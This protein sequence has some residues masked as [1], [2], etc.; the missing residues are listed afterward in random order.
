LELLLLQ[1]ILPALLEQ[2]HT[3]IWLKALIRGWCRVVA[4]LLNLQSYLLREQ[5]D[6]PEPAVVE[7][8]QH[9]DLGAAHQ[10]L[11]QREGPFGFQPYVRPKWFPA[12]LLGLLLCVCASLVVASL[13][14]MTLPVW[15]GRRVMALWMVGAPAPSPPVLPPTPSPTTGESSSI[16]YPQD[17]FELH[18]MADSPLGYFTFRYIVKI[19]SRVTSPYLTLPHLTSPYLTLPHLTF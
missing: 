11:L 1:V 19:Q 8:P 17:R 6:E 2:S 18:L 9:P 16:Y 14:A 13:V 4:W 15:I 5:V 3:R 12:R 10:A 7:E